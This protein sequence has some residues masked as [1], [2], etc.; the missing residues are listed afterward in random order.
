MTSFAAF[1]ELEHA[2]ARIVILRAMPEC[3]VWSAGHDIPSCP[4]DGGIRWAIRIHWSCVLR[5]VQDC[6]VPVIAMVAGSVWGG[7]TDLCITCD[8]IICSDDATF[9]ITP[10]KSA[11]P[12][13]P[14]ARPLSGGRRAAQSEGTVFH[15]PTN[16]CPGR[17]AAGMRD[18]VVLARR[19]G[20]GHVRRRRDDHPECA[21]SRAGAQATV[22]ASA[23]GP[24]LIHR[25][26]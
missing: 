4:W 10:P 23:A 25:D 8:L 24:D 6:P 22:S 9:A 15:R 20:S 21:L 16:Q 13:A 17:P 7:G 14:R 1:D 2:A 19:P 5:R 26:L 18:H 3:K 11:C 12:T